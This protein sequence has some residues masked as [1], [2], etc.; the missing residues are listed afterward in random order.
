MRSNH[1][2]RHSQDLQVEQKV[3]DEAFKDARREHAQA[4]SDIMQK[5]GRIKKDEK[6]MDAKVCFFNF[7]F[8]ILVAIVK[9]KNLTL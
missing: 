6:A 4:R 5:K 9:H 7:H 1:R 3:C 2:T 8:L